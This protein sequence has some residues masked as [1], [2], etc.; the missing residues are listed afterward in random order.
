MKNVIDAVN[1]F[2]GEFPMDLEGGVIDH[3]D[4]LVIFCPTTKNRWIKGVMYNGITRFNKDFFTQVC[5]ESE[6]NSEVTSLSHFAGEELFKEYLAA[7]KTPLEKQVDYT[8]EEFWKDAPEWANKIG[9]K[10]GVVNYWMDDNSYQLCRSNHERVF[11][12]NCYSSKKSSFLFLAT[13]PQPKPVKPVYTKAMADN[14]ELPSVGMECVAVYGK[15]EEKVTVAHVNDKGQFACIDDRGDYFIH[16]PNEDAEETF[17]PIDTRTSKEKAIDYMQYAY[18][19]SNSMEDVFS[20]IEK[21][22]VEGVTFK[23]EE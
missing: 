5:T 10:S 14:G 3:E 6:F 22:Y 18:D 1:E 16:Y 8:S 4:S 20:E 17:E 7:D 11:F 2:N 21:G 19:K 13:R 15:G 23:G 9:T 12:S